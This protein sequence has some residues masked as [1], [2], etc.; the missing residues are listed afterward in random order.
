MAN[1]VG[2]GGYRG[3]TPATVDQGDLAKYSPGPRVARPTPLLENFSSPEAM[4]KNA[5]PP[6][7]SMMASHPS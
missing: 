7:P 4:M 2:F 3:R 6:E 5:V 1:Q